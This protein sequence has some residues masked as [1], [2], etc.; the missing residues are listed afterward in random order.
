MKIP[1]TYKPSQSVRSSSPVRRVIKR[2]LCVRSVAILFSHFFS[3]SVFAPQARCLL[4]KG[5]SRGRGRSVD[6][7]TNGRTW[8][9]NSSSSITSIV[10]PHL[11][12]SFPMSFATPLARPSFRF[13]RHHSVAVRRWATASNL[14]SYIL[15]FA[16]V[17]GPSFI[18]SFILFYIPPKEQ[19]QAGTVQGKSFWVC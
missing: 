13:N 12:E 17:T 16:H 2:L 15:S 9:S 4:Q 3:H 10:M 5:R 19:Q 18:H 11:D 7:W 14:K 6:R 1:E 8:M